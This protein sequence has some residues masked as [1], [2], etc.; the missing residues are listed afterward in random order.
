M[1]V[2]NGRRDRGL[3]FERWSTYRAFVCCLLCRRCLRARVLDSA[4]LSD[5]SVPSKSSKTPVQVRTES[6]RKSHAQQTWIMYWFGKKRRR[7]VDKGCNSRSLPPLSYVS[8]ELR[9]KKS[10]DRRSPQHRHHVSFRFVSFLR[11]I[12]QLAS[13]LLLLP[14]SFLIKP[15]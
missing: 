4:R 9:K 5:S 2:I 8:P 10:G 12:R 11:A 3:L 6:P 7:G 1:G 15:T 13:Q 14:R